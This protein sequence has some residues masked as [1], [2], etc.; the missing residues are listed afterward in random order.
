V[1][2]IALRLPAGEDVSDAKWLAF[3][4]GLPKL[5]QLG[6][7]PWLWVKHLGEH[8]HLVTSRIDNSGR[9]WAGKWEALRLIEATQQLERKFGL[10]VTPGLGGKDRKQVRLTGGEVSRLRRQFRWR[11][12]AAATAALAL[13]LTWSWLCWQSRQSREELA[14]SQAQL[15]WHREQL[16]QPQEKLTLYEDALRKI[17]RRMTTGQPPSQAIRP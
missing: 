9:V 4:L 15:A 13:A 10:T 1:W 14:Q 2:H 6:N 3:S 8:A 7:R 16:S 12:A 11:C 17:L 5:L